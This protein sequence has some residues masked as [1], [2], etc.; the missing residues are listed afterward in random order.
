MSKKIKKNNGILYVV[1]SL[2]AV[3]SILTSVV[4]IGL[5]YSAVNTI[6]INNGGVYNNYESGEQT[7]PEQITFGAQPGT[8]VV[9]DELEYGTSRSGRLD[10]TAGAT[11]TPGGLFSI[12][13]YGATK[14][15]SKVEVEIVTG[16][17]DTLFKFSVATSTGYGVG[18]GAGLIATTTVAS[19]T[20]I[21]LDSV[22]HQGN[23][24]DSWLWE[25]GIAINGQFD[26][27]DGGSAASTTDYI[28][29]QGKYYITCHER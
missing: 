10:F 26:A 28:V 17:N 21:I 7:V 29:M 18:A 27:N 19:S 14:L 2:F 20:T 13:N 1:I 23:T 22:L 3:F 11:T 6:N 8:W 9:V 16:S 4:G 25:K 24:L 5:A 12:I 15:C